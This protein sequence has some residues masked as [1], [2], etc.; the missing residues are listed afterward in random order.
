MIKLFLITLLCVTLVF[1]HSPGQN[2]Q[3]A[4]KQPVNGFLSKADHHFMGRGNSLVRRSAQEEPQGGGRGG[5][6]DFGGGFNFG[7]G[8]KVGAGRK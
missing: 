6:F 2:F 3:D 4:W 1:A 7:A 8:G 5:G